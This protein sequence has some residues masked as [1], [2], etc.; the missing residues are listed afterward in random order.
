MSKTKII[1]TL[2]TTDSEEVL[3]ALIVNGMSVA[4]INFSHQTMKRIKEELIQ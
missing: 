2:S 3:R 1:C 4:R